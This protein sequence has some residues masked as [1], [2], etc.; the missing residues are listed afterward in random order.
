LSNITQTFDLSSTIPD[1]VIDG[2]GFIPTLLNVAHLVP[3]RVVGGPASC[4]PAVEAWRLNESDVKQQNLIQKEKKM[5]MTT[6]SH[7]PKRVV[8]EDDEEEEKSESLF[9]PPPN[10][11]RYLFL[12]LAFLWLCLNN[13]RVRKHLSS[14]T[15]WLL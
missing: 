5:S 4:R 6:L 12:Q 14:F 13:H 8:A 10:L 11:R 15:R 2:I 9:E 3:E 7:G 1:E